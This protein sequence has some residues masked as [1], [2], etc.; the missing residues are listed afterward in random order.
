[1][2]DA[3]PVYTFEWDGTKWQEVVVELNDIQDRQKGDYFKYGLK[4]TPT[5]GILMK[6]KANLNYVQGKTLED[7][8]SDLATLKSNNDS[9]SPP[10]KDDENFRIKRE[11]IDLYEK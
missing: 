1:M 3:L 10:H 5:C 2:F 4:D 7:G 8:E 9:S 11:T 6:P